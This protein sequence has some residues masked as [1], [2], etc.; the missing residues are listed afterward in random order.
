M[1]GGYNRPPRFG[2]NLKNIHLFS[3]VILFSCGRWEYEDRSEPIELSLPETY[4]TLVAVDTIYST[5]DSFGNTIYAIDEEPSSDYVWDTLSQAFTTIT[6]SRQELHW[7][8]DDLD[9][10]IVGYEYKWSSDTVWTFTNL[11]SGVFYVPIRSE[12]DVFSF[13]VR[14]IDDD[15]NKDYTPSRLTLPIRN[16]SP[17]ISFKY[18]SNPLIDD[19]GSDT[20][21]T[22]PT[23]TFIWDL[24][25]QDGNETI[26]D[27]FYAIDDTCETCWVA[28][29]GE[30]TSTTLVELEPGIHTFFVK[31]RDIAG[32]ESSIIQFPDSSRS[33]EAQAW[34]VKPVLGDILIVDD[35]PLDNSNNAL[36]WYSGMM[37]TLV[38]SQGFSY[39]EIGDELPYSSSDLSATLSYFKSVIWFTGYNNTASASNTYLNA[40]SNIN[41]YVS[42]GGNIFINPINFGASTFEWFPLD[43]TTILNPNGRLFA[44]VTVENPIDSTLDLSLSSLIA[45]RVKGFWPSQEQFENLTEIYHM[46]D[47]EGN[48]AWSGNPTVCSMGQYRVSPTELSGKVVIMT[49]P[50]HDG[51]RPKLQGNG[52]AIKLFQYLFENEF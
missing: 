29:G 49:L 7:W 4:L 30:E 35:Y 36:S 50:L 52:S 16:S 2:D 40:G 37:D 47:P 42:S 48:D 12:L 15:D 11:E 33:Y 18:L 3:L 5:I 21:F 24:Y 25:D 19:I 39:W 10:Q 44:G 31:C 43:S 34:Y 9:G 20:S 41:N 23:R 17:E 28:L 26:T 1:E 32:A 51:Y 27:V 13:Q 6:T 8:G 45:I 46:A 22:F 14:S 38:G